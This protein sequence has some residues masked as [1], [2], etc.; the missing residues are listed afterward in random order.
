MYTTFIAKKACDRRFAL[1]VRRN[2]LSFSVFLYAPC[3]SNPIF[4]TLL[5]TTSR[6]LRTDEGIYEGLFPKN[7][8]GCGGH[9]TIIDN[10]VRASIPRVQRLLMSL[11]ELEREIRD[12]RAMLNDKSE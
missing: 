9:S 10:M 3:Y 6:R 1:V 12:S 4:A 11:D 5:P 7:L 8:R 2:T